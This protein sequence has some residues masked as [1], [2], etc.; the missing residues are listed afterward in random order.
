MDNMSEEKRE[1]IIEWLYLMTGYA[2][3]YWERK[4]DEQLEREYEKTWNKHS[5]QEGDH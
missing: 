1:S 5:I 4:T 2:Y 3:S